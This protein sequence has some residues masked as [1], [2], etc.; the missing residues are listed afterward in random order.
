MSPQPGPLDPWDCWRTAEAGPGI[1]TTGCL[2]IFP[3]S[4]TGTARL[5]TRFIAQPPSATSTVTTTTIT[6]TTTTEAVASARGLT[7]RPALEPRPWRHS[8][9]PPSTCLPDL[10]LARP[11]VPPP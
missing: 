6:E 11:R 9:L 10:R 2:P 1:L 8:G 5:G 4:G 3:A 7:P